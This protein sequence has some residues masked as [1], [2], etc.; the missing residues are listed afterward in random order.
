MDLFA[1]ERRMKIYEIL[2]VQGA[3]TTL[4]L[5]Q[6]FR[7]SVET[8]RKDLLVM[9]QNNALIRVHGGAVRTGSVKTYANLSER[10][11]DKKDEK[12][13]LSYLAAKLVHEG[14]IL[15]ID[16]GSTAIELTEVLIEQFQKLTII[17][18]STDVF[19]RVNTQSDFEVL[20]C[21]GHYLREERAFYGSFVQDML[22]K[23][24]VN[25]VFL[26]PHAISLKNGI[27]EY[28]PQLY[29]VQKR[30]IQTG[31]EIIVLADS[32]KYEKNALL[33]VCDMKSSF[34]YVTDAALPEKLKEIYKNNDIQIITS[35]A[36][37][38]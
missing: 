18:H 35:P 11:E 17:T 16:S 33:K 31:D 3:V 9:E 14:D 38:T 4:A 30:L 2:K 5:S 20:L 36:D 6:K 22:E 29:E 23:V 15:A 32:S 8:I 13:A 25:K 10:L 26:F 7:V 19:E 21:G 34:K 1:N 27:C 37:I 24:H 12:R 28:L